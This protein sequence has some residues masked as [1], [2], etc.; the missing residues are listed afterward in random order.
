MDPTLVRRLEACQS[1]PTLPAVALE[2]VDLCQR[3]E[4]DLQRISQTLSRDQAL[5][6]RLLRTANSASV[7]ARGRVTTVSRAVALLGTNTVLMLALGFTFLRGRKRTSAA[8]F[9]HAAHWRRSLLCAIA[10]RLLAEREG[11]NPEELFL[12]GLLQDIG[13]L[14]L[15]ELSPEEYGSLVRDGAGDHARL[16]ALERGRFGTDHA[17]VSA[18][19]ARRWNLPQL[20]EAS[21]LG[22]HDPNRASAAA[23]ELA[24]AVRCVYRSGFLADLWLPGETPSAEALGAAASRLGLDPRELAAVLGDLARAI[25]EVAREFEFPLGNPEDLERLLDQARELL[26]EVG[27]RTATRA[28]EATLAVK[29]LAEENLSLERRSSRDALTGLFNRAYLDAEFPPAFETAQA[30]GLPLTIALGDIDHFKRVNDSFGHLAG[31][32]V[33]SAVARAFAGAVR[34]SD[35]VARYGGEEFLIVLAGTAQEGAR[36]VTERIRR[37]VEE[38]Q[39]SVGAGEPVKVTISLGQA[40]AVGGGAFHSAEELLAAADACLYRAK[41]GGRNRV[42]AHGE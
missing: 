39:I 3:E 2:L 21:A 5:V 4:V 16:A 28:R 17:E 10:G 15:A 27:L 30:R 26:V 20:I 7:A 14:A 25:P 8:G 40:T 22:S 19:L 23:P 42:V 12:G 36:V 18:L 35:W 34:R 1:L 24:P 31:D 6:A 29:A 11:L 32:E 9:D 13:M 41:Q 38:L 33:L 37:K